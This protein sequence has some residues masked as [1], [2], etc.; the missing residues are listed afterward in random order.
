MIVSQRRDSEDFEGKVGQSSTQ[1]LLNKADKGTQRLSSSPLPIALYRFVKPRLTSLREDFW[2]PGADWIMGN[3]YR[4]IKDDTQGRFIHSDSW[5]LIGTISPPSIIS[6][7]RQV[8]NDRHWVISI[9]LVNSNSGSSEGV[10]DLKR[11][12]FIPQTVLVYAMPSKASSPR[13]FN[14]IIIFS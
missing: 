8:H 3:C 13:R 10:C 6:P 5:R 2:D 12:S 14:P 9:E 7:L 11:L 4:I 1:F